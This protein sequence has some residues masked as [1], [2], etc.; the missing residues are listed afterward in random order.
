M[1]GDMSKGAFLK[2]KANNMVKWVA[3]EVGPEN[4]SADILADMNARSEVEIVLL[5]SKLHS[6]KSV[7]DQHN[8]AGLGALAESAMPVVASIVAM[9]RQRAHMHDK[10]WRYMQLFVEVVEQ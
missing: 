8:W 5:A 2:Q 1:Q 10:F 6:N 9:I 4:M 7:V 3:E